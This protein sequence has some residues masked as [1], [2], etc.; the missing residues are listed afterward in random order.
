MQQIAASGPAGMPVV[1]APIDKSKGHFAIAFAFRPGE[2]MVR[3]SYEIPYPNNTVGAKNSAFIPIR[4]AACWSSRLPRCKFPAKACRAGGQEQ[5]MNIYGR[6]N[7]AANATV[8]VNVSGTAPPPSATT[9]A[10]RAGQGREAQDAQG[11]GR[12]RKHS[13][14]FPGV[15]TFSSGRSSRA[16]SAYLRVGRNF[17]GA[18]A[19]VVATGP[20]QDSADYSAVSVKSLAQKTEVPPSCRRKSTAPSLENVN[21]AVATSLDYLKEQLF[22]LELRHQAG[23]ISDEEYASER[24][25][26]EKVLRDLVRG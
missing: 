12:G 17:F 11:C 24:A 20:S 19:V 3:Y 14:R 6:E 4:F 5:G 23:T 22:R 15:S 13:G 10:I 9:V 26:A 7:L 1:Q 21:A 2:N 25:R 8:A 16:S 18:Q